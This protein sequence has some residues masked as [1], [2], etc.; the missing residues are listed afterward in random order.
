MLD[1]LPQPSHF[2][3]LV[4]RDEADAQICAAV[5]NDDALSDLPL[6]VI[7]TGT[8]PS[9]RLAGHLGTVGLSRRGRHIVAAHTGHWVQLDDPALLLDVIREAV[10]TKS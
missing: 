7:S 8:T 10:A 5:P 4:H 3:Q 6:W 2:T 9:S 1:N